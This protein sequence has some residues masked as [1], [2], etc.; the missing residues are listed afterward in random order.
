MDTAS[1]PLFSEENL[2]LLLVLAG[3]FGLII[4]SFINVVIYR[5]P[6]MIMH[7]NGE[8]K[9]PFNLW[10]PSSH[11]PHCKHPLRVIDNIPVVSF[12][13]LRRRCAHCNTLISSQ[14]CIIEMVSTLLIVSMTWYYGLSYELFAILLLLLALL[15]LSTIDFNHH[16]LPDAITLP[17]IW[18]GLLVN[19]FSVFASPESAILGAIAGYLSLWSL[20]WLFKL[21]T[22][23]EGLGYGDF[24]L[25]AALGAWGGWQALPS[26][27]LLSSLAGSI[28]GILLIL[29]KGRSR[30]IPLA[31]GPWL[32][33]AGA[34]VIVWGGQIN[35]LLNRVLGVSLIH[36]LYY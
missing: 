1:M 34:L 27:I 29:C 5:L 20:Y 19:T 2:L 15:T 33:I 24:K 9:T 25:L 4:G 18:L 28:A 8:A 3:I 7:H 14:Y 21:L 36:I 26:I 31:F 11:C 6:L 23:K 17:L 32:A 13:L 12:I 30:H 16:L 35:Q 22:H 10:K